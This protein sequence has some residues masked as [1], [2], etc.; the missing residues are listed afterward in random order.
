MH[1]MAFPISD[2]YDGEHFFNPEPSIRSDDP[3]RPRMSIWRFLLARFFKPDPSV[4]APWPKHIENQHYPPPPAEADSI[5]FIGH[6][7]FLL[8]VAGL[9]VLTDPVFYQR[10][11]PTQLI[12]PKRVR[13]PGIALAALPRIDILLLSHNHYDHLDLISLRK[14]RRRF[15]DMLIITG[16]GNARYLAK[17][18]IEGAVE[19][20]WWQTDQTGL[21]KVTAVPARHFAARSLWD[22]NKTLWCGFLLEVAGKT[23]YFA[24]DTASTKFFAEIRARLGAPDLALLPIGAYEPRGF[25]QNAHM[26]PEDA[27]QAFIAL[28]PKNAIGMHFGTFQLT[29][30]P[31]DAPQKDLATSLAAAHINPARFTTLDCGESTAILITD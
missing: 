15:R 21:A 2:H 14:L 1:I 17:K 22:R 12:G 28:Q 4:W 30:E 9:N 31:I 27:V 19:L 23:I 7:S 11:S 16:L 10:C 8:R 20:D 13:A 18:G 6:S 25:M 26:N 29:A 3:D 5:T 24:G